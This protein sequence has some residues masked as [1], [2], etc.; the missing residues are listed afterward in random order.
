MSRK[1]YKHLYQ[2][3]ERGSEEEKKL[4][5]VLKT[6]YKAASSKGH[7]E[8]DVREPVD[9]LMQTI[10]A[11]WKKL[12]TEPFF[13]GNRPQS[14]EV[15]KLHRKYKLDRPDRV[16][17]AY[18]DVLKTDERGPAVSAMYMFL[19]EV[20][21]PAQQADE[22]LDRAIKG[23][24]PGLLESGYGTCPCCFNVQAVKGDGM[25]THGY[26]K[27]NQW[28]RSA[29]CQG[30]GEPPLELSTV[31]LEKMIGRLGEWIERR[32]GEIDNPNSVDSVWLEGRGNIDQTMPDF[33]K[34]LDRYLKSLPREVKM[35]KEEL[36]LLETKLKEWSNKLPS[37]SSPTL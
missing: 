17:A 11:S 34:A 18:E 12:V 13:S 1:T 8:S 21:Y 5:D 3:Y 26:R 19:E 9:F 23:S 35:A 28:T 16:L 7:Y 10:S 14:P 20:A 29:S 33:H 25:I 15:V 4:S 31:G 37:V 2:A 24:R 36:A 32:Q 27:P 30:T 6:I 22:V